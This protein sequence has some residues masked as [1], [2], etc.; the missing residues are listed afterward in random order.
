MLIGGSETT[1]LRA[2]DGFFVA[3]A[4]VGDFDEA[5][6]AGF[7]GAPDFANEGLDFALGLDFVAV[8]AAGFDAG[9]GVGLATGFTVALNFVVAGLTVA[10]VFRCGAP[11]PFEDRD[12]VALT[13]L[14]KT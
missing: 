13:R 7:P 9:F 10:G 2:G 14:S 5:T 4:V 1:A 8:L 11:S 12:T 3:F 6:P